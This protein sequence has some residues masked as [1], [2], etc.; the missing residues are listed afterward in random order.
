LGFYDIGLW[1]SLQSGRSS[2]FTMPPVRQS[3]HRRSSSARASRPSQF[4][5]L[6]GL[7]AGIHQLFSGRSTVGPRSPT[8]DSPKSPRFVLGL[9]NLPTTR[10]NVPYLNRTASNPSRS[11]SQH[12]YAAP[13][14]SSPPITES[15][16]TPISSR[17]IT[18][19]SLRQQVQQ[20]DV[21]AAPS[22]VR[23]NSARR[24]VG[25]DPAEQHLAELAQ[26]G[27]DRRR[28]K[29]KHKGRTCGPKIKN[30][31]IRAKILTCFISGLVNR[32]LVSLKYL[33]HC[34]LIHI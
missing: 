22:H 2:T 21:S 30:R 28:R 6:G 23:H 7:R 29:R 8:P 33:M 9:P 34:M 19:N 15:I 11:N 27:R 24:F 5:R 17:P 16:A 1:G 10:L 31:K 4:S 13:A 26:A 32:S 20:P 12:S 3:N 18:P 14:P 25:V